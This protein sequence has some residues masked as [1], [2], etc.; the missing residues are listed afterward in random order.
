M[1]YHIN[2]GKQI[3]CVTMK[4]DQR[5]AWRVEDQSGGAG[6]GGQVETRHDNMARIKY[7]RLWDQK[8]RV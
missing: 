3:I 2:D 7:M 6:R 8:P 1:S 5:S 4:V